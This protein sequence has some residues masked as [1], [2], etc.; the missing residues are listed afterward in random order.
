MATASGFAP[1][2]WATARDAV[3]APSRAAIS[4]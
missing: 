1:Q 3:G 4:A 2:A